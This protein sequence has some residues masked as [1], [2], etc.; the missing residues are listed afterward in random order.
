MMR[1]RLL[2]LPIPR[3]LIRGEAS[4]ADR[5]AGALKGAGVQISIV[6]GAGHGM[7]WENPEGF[8]GAVNV[9]LPVDAS[10]PS[11]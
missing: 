2:Q 5:E 4:G 7:M 3:A 6:P 11:R 8:I 1:E 9:A 10:S